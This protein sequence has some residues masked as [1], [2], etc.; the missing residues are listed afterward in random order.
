VAPA[1]S[2]DQAERMMDEQL[3]RNRDDAAST[4]GR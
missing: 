4:A 1:V 2:D 3:R